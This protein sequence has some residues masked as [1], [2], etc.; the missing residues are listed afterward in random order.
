MKQRLLAT[1]AVLV[2]AFAGLTLFVVLTPTCAC[3]S[4]YVSPN[5]VVATTVDIPAGGIVQLEMLQ[6][7]GINPGEQTAN[8]VRSLDQVV[9][10]RAIR[11]IKA[12]SHLTTT[13]F[14]EPEPSSTPN[15]P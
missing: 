8:L 14:A 2:L 6:V 4:P 9:G 13:M 5:V 1:I 15:P 12:G 3:A 11:D 7:Q 10:R